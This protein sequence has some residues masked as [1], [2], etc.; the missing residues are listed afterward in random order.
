[1]ALPICRGGPVAHRVPPAR[2]PDAQRGHGAVAEADPRRRVGL[3]P[4]QPPGRRDLHQLPAPQTRP[5]GSAPHPHPAR[6]GLR[7]AAMTLNARLLTGLLAVTVAGLAIMGLVSALVLNGYLMHRDR[8]STR[9]NS[10]HV[11]IS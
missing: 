11:K 4:R 6:R 8:K 1:C 5:A 2:L 3:G 9:L 10:S 7:A